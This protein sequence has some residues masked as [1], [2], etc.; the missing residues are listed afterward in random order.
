[1]AGTGRLRDGRGTWTGLLIRAGV[2]HGGLECSGGSEQLHRH[3]GMRLTGL[4]GA[5]ATI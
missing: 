3:L 5:G 4:H 2:G 1:V